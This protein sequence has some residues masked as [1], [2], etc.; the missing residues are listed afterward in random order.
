MIELYGMS[1]PNVLKV[2][3][4]LEELGLDYRFIHVDLFAGEQFRDA[5]QALNPNAKVP[6]LVDAEEGDTIFESGAILIYLAEKYGRFLPANG[7][8]RYDVLKWLMLQVSTVGPLLG[9]MNHFNMYA[10]EGNEYALGRY[11]REAH[12][13]YTLLDD[14]L[15]AEEWLAGDYSIA[16]IATYPWTDYL[17]R[18]GFEMKDFLGIARWRGVI[19]GRDAVQR[20]RALITGVQARDREMFGAA[21]QEGVKRFLGQA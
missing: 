16:D 17:E 11:R 20:A 6:V 13:I 19:E 21:P 5:F 8:A 3:I 7:T 18:H 15:K 10:P 14:R 4:L 12:R 2:V 1:S 9:Q